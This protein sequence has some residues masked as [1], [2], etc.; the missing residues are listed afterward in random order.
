MPL[1]AGPRQRCGVEWSVCLIAARVGD[2]DR[3]D[4]GDE[5]ALAGSA[6]LQRVPIVKIH[7]VA[8]G[9]RSSFRLSRRQ[10]E[11]FGRTVHLPAVNS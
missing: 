2:V 10:H 4:H 11:H 5:V 3:S 7:I 9:Q 6:V 8:Q 1:V